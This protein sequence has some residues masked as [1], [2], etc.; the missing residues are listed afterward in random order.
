MMLSRR[1]KATP[2]GLR[3][4]RLRHARVNAPTLRELLP[5]ATQVLVELTFIRDA[6]L[7]HGSHALPVFPAA[8]APFISA[9]PYGDCDGTYDLNEKIFAMLR[10]ESRRSTG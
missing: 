10:E 4:D 6:P 3:L 8:Q 1:R 2:A 9:C 5:A 7:A